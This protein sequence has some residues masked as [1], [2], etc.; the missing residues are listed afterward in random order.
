[1]FRFHLMQRRIE[2]TVR[3]LKREKAAYK[4][5]GLH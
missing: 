2:R 4:A 5:A 3:K 1:M